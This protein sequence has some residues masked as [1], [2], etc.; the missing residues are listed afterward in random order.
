[1]ASLIAA[2][3]IIAAGA[4]VYSNSLKGPEILDDAASISRNR[5]IRHL[6]P[7]WEAMKAPPQETTAGRP[8]VCLS[9]AINYAISGLDV[10][11]YHVVNISVHILAALTLFGVIR[12]TLL[13]E[14]LRDR[15]DRSAHVLAAICATVWVV[16]PL[17]TGAVTYMIQRTE[18]MMGLFYLLTMYCSIMG[19][20]GR[21]SSFWYTAAVVFCAVGMGTKEVMVTA[22][23]MVL[24]YDRVFVARRWGEVFARRWKFYAALAGTWA[25]LV[26]LVWT[27][28]RSTSAGFGLDIS[29]FQYA[30]TQS[31][32]IMH[33]LRLTFYPHPLVL[34]YAWQV[35]EGFSQVVIPGV[36]LLVLLVGTLAA[37]RW[38]AEWGFL[39]VW[40]FVI[41]AP[42]SSF[43]PIK[44]LAFEHRM[45]LSLAGVI[46]AVV[47]AAYVVGSRVAGRYKMALGVV[48]LV[49]VTAAA[50]MLGWRTYLR[51]VDYSD[52]L[53]MWSE[54]IKRAPH[55]H[56]AHN[57]LGYAYRRRGEYKEAIRHYD[58]AI[59]LNPT[60]VRA[61]SN[62]GAAYGFMGMHD[63]AIQDFN[64]AIELNPGMATAY[65]N[66]GIAWTIK[67]DLRRAIANLD[68]A[69]RLKPDYA[70]AYVRRGHA[71]VGMKDYKRAM[72][73]YETALRIIPDLKEAQQARKELLKEMRAGK[74]PP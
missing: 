1:V 50:A 27:G 74:K 18:S 29:P 20:R 2:C 36:G 37:L 9:L 17:Q 26:M 63:R 15:F 40:F 33:Y 10:W 68:V 12:R 32:V 34:D 72:R 4:A 69:V 59:E 5:H 7:I 14:R 19:L 13:T 44:D 60:Y 11:S 58:R 65:C 28:P 22:P 67:G 73:D 24:I 30:Q 41:L 38:R 45:Y 47:I 46:A 35:A 43:V 54:T 16:H 52:P 53:R 8:I 55:N 6:W 57:N 49:L 42:T 62:R 21:R 23:V 71:Y 39:G 51:N 25:V 56:R 3:V 48:G 70:G 66:R 61:Y 31:H 64:K